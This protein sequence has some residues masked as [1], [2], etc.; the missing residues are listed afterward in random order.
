MA[1]RKGI[2]KRGNIWWICYS[3]VD[4]KAIR[5]TTGST[6]QRDA[7]ALLVHRKQAVLEGRN[8][9]LKQRSDITLKKFSIEY[10]ECMM[11]Q[12]SY[13]TKEAC[14]RQLVR[15][16]GN[17]PLR[18]FTTRL[19]DNYKARL[20]TG[21]TER[22]TC[23][24][25]PASVNRIIAT[26]KHTFTTAH[27]WR[28]IGDESLK[29]I[30]QVKLLQVDNARLTFLDT[31]EID[32]LLNAC[33]NRL[34]PIVLAGIHSGLRPGELL[35]LKWEQV[36]LKNGFIHVEK[37]KNGQSRQVPVSPTLTPNR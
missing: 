7:E 25:K 32:A 11:V 10:L 9:V 31:D 28:L 23:G 4:G 18:L 5:E 2:Y 22:R 33:D 15:E 24:L 8:P 26:L 14:M 1:R 19:I 3:G 34:R 29:Q 12:R 6:R 35:S 37:A 21:Q 13:Q 16:F 17:L 20:M 30:R 36:N 27:E